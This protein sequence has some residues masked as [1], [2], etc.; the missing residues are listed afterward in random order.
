M[1]TATRIIAALAAAVMIFTTFGCSGSPLI[2]AKYEE[3][4]FSIEIPTGVYIS[5]LLDSYQQA[6]TKVPDY[7]KNMFHKSQL[8]DGKPTKQWIIDNAINLVKQYVLINKMIKDMD[9][10]V[11]EEDIDYWNN[12]IEEAWKDLDNSQVAMYYDNGVS[13]DSLIK[14]TITMSVYY[15][16]LFMAIYGKGGEKEVSEETL[17]NVFDEKY[18]KVKIM[19]A[20]IFNSK[21]EKLSD[22]QI[23]E[24]RSTMQGYVDRINKGEDFDKVYKD[25]YLWN[26]KRVYMI[27]YPDKKNDYEPPELEEEKDTSEMTPVELEDY[28][29]D[30]GIERIFSRDKDASGI[31]PMIFDKLESMPV[32]GKAELWFNDE[33]YFVLQRFDMNERKSLFDRYYETLLWGFKG[34]EYREFL[35]TEADKIDLK[36]DELVIKKN[37][38]KKLVFP[39]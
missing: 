1:K 2:A 4:D 26:D 14:T 37:S 29:A 32:G 18:M 3:G 13:K 15:N 33:Y 20:R 30:K 24:I 22:A 19:S 12:I 21:D 31:P 23:E 11:P 27:E 39:W 38:P 7:T 36:I 16:E 8:I 5:C 25:Y 28:I 35:K 9:V 34:E 6:E 10:K 17:K